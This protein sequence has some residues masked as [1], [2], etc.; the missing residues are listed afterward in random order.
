MKANVN[1]PFSTI[2]QDVVTIQEQN[3]LKSGFVYGQGRN[4][5]IEWVSGQ[6]EKKTGSM[7]D[8]Y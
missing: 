1:N 7:Q 5:R 6:K 3:G 8:I 2:K 4:S